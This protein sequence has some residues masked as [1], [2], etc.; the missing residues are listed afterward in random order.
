MGYH[1][2]TNALRVG[3]VQT[4]SNANYAN[5]YDYAKTAINA[6]FIQGLFERFFIANKDALMYFATIPSH[7]KIQHYTNF[8][9]IN[10]YAYSG[11]LEDDHHSKFRK[12]QYSYNNLTNL[13]FKHANFASKNPRLKKLANAA[14]KKNYGLVKKFWDK[15]D[16]DTLTALMSIGHYRS[17]VSR[18]SKKQKKLQKQVVI[19]KKGT[20]AK[21]QKQQ[22]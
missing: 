2:N 19:Q 8:S 18:F 1:L 21:F 10:F 6:H 11:L 16:T 3:H 13:F 15:F 22:K 12:F 17:L 5:R 4:W 9:A 7:V 14:V 20:H